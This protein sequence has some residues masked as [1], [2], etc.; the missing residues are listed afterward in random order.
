MRKS[1]VTDLSLLQGL[2]DYDSRKTDYCQ[3][4]MHVITEFNAAV[5]NKGNCR[6]FDTGQ[7]IFNSNIIYQITDCKLLGRI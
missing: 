3:L 6:V 5:V 7:I 4:L 1:I 2:Q